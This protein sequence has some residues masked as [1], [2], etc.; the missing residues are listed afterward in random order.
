MSAFNKRTI[1]MRSMAAPH[2]MP[3][4]WLPPVLGNSFQCAIIVANARVASA[5][6]CGLTTLNRRSATLAKVANSFWSQQCNT[7]NA[8]ATLASPCAVNL[9]AYRS[10]SLANARHSLSSDRF[11]VAS[12]HAT[13]ATSWE[14]DMLTQRYAALAVAVASS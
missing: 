7:A 5:S 3:V 2:P 12:A 13:L 1:A 9:L 10:I 14:L 6:Y 8:H 4:P 11:I